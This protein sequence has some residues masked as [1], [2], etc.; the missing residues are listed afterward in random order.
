[1]HDFGGI[2]GQGNASVPILSRNHVEYLFELGQRLPLGG[3]QGIAT[4]KGRNFRYPTIRLIPVQD[5][6]IVIPIHVLTS[7][8]RV[9][10]WAS[11][12]RDN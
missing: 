1:M 5:H 6:F 7:L 3:H 9:L 8:L 10:G 2:G 11:D 12:G 4:L